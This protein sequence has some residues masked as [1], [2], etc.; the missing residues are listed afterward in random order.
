MSNVAQGRCLCQ[1]V[2]LS[3]TKMNH[4][5]G[6][7]HCRMCRKWGGS[8][9]LVIDCESEV[10]FEGTEDISIYQSSDWAERGFCRNCGTHLFYRLKQNQQYFIPVGLFDDAEDLYFEHQIF[11]DE[12]PDYYSFANETHNMTGAEF[13]AQV[14]SERQ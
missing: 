3:T 14:A 10:N 1:A 2:S 5:I 13:F 6:A 9:L 8:A 11:I 4:Q 12:K 7:C